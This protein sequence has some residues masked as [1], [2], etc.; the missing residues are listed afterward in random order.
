MKQNTIIALVGAGVG[1]VVLI[2]LSV[3]AA[4]LFTGGEAQSPGLSASQKTAVKEALRDFGKIQAGLDVGITYNQ[5]GDFLIPARRAVNELMVTLPN[6]EI[7]KNLAGAVDAFADS[8]QIW[9][10]KIDDPRIERLDPK[11]YIEQKILVRYQIDTWMEVEAIRSL[12]WRQAGQK[13]AA[14]RRL[15]AEAGV[16]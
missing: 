12:I 10:L 5:F 4:F 15:A 3:F 2:I 13:L 14:A 9:K 7:T 11:G 8:R 16:E 6:S 1:V